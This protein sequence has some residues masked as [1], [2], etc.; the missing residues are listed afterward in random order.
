[1]FYTCYRALLSGFS[2]HG[3][4]G[5]MMGAN[6]V[7]VA[8]WFPRGSV[9]PKLLLCVVVIPEKLPPFHSSG[10]EIVFHPSWKQRYPYGFPWGK[11]GGCSE[12]STPSTFLCSLRFPSFTL[13]DLRAVLPEHFCLWCHRS[14]G[15]PPQCGARDQVCGLKDTGTIPPSAGPGP[16]MCFM[17][18]VWLNRHLGQ[19]Y[20]NQG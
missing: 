9:L 20:R 3:N 1:M 8:E 15:R 10:F 17:E 13:R 6:G 18:K 7:M 4:E 16:A 5:R 11:M 12:E 14:S 2:G 19:R